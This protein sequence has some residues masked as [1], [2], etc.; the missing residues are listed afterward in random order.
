MAN[1]LQEKF[2]QL[3]WLEKSLAALA[4]VGGTLIAGCIT[5][6][7]LDHFYGIPQITTLAAATLLALALSIVVPSLYMMMPTAEE[8]SKIGK[9]I[10]DN[11]ARATD[12]IAS[13]GRGMASAGKALFSGM[14]R[15]SVRSIT[16]LLSIV[17][18]LVD[19]IKKGKSIEHQNARGKET[20]AALEELEGNAAPP[21]SQQRSQQKPQHQQQQESAASS[22]SSSNNSQP[23]AVSRQDLKNLTP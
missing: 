22:S 4:L 15:Q 2:N 19:L 7:A 5:G 9:V 1:S 8:R 11:I 16:R 3:N 21:H 14:A 13:A 17:K 23:S 12:N 20:R 10:T 18:L 6:I